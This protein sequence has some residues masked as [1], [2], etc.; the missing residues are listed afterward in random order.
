VRLWAHWI[1]AKIAI[2][3][4]DFN[5][6][7]ITL[8]QPYAGNLKGTVWDDYWAA[9]TRTRFHIYNSKSFLDKL[10]EFYMDT[11]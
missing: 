9:R 4:V 11:A 1:P 3:D 7:T 6:R 8:E 5:S 10:G 2:Q